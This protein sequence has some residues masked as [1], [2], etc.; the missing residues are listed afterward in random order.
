MIHNHEV[1]GSIPGPATKKIRELRKRDSLFFVYSAFA[2]SVG[3]FKCVV[4]SFDGILLQ[5]Q[6][7]G[8]GRLLAIWISVK[9]QHRCAA[10]LNCAWLSTLQNSLPIGGS[11]TALDDILFSRT[12]CLHHLVNSPVSMLQI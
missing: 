8:M 1:P 11:C 6:K 7:D 12:S 4:L 3:C 2:L 5:A 9:M 10:F